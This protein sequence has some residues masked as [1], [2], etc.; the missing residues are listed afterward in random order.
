MYNVNR[1]LNAVAFICS[2]LW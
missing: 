1:L 2:S